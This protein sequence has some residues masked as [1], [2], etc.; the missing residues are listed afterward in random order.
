MQAGVHHVEQGHGI[1]VDL[2]P[3]LCR[4][5]MPWLHCGHVRHAN[6]T[7]QTQRTGHWCRTRKTQCQGSGHRAWVG[8]TKLREDP[9]LRTHTSP[10]QTFAECSRLHRSPQQRCSSVSV[11]GRNITQGGPPTQQGAWM[12]WKSKKRPTPHAPKP[13]SA[14]V[15]TCALTLHCPVV[16]H[17]KYLPPPPHT[18]PV[19]RC[20]WRNRGGPQLC[21]SNALRSHFRR[22]TTSW[23]TC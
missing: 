4:F 20:R 3:P 15:P 7:L 10:R 19:T 21:N 8:Q 13:Q 17:A 1:S 2:V 5:P 22:T 11:T 16:S 9:L 18:L 6:G 12:G 14:R 23:S